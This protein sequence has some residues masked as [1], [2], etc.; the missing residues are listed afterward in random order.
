MA[1]VSSTL[2]AWS[3][4]AGSNNPSGSTTIGA[5]LD[6][7]LREMQAVTR[8]FLAGKG[9]AIASAA[10]MDL[11]TMDGYYASVTGNT[12]VTGLGTES[13]GISYWLRTASTPQFT[14]GAAAIVLPGGANLVAAAGDI[15]RFTS[16]GS[17]V[18]VLSGFLPA[19]I[20]GTGSMVRAT[21]PTL[22]GA[23]LGS[24]TVA[25]TQA[26]SDNSTK[27][28]TTAYIDRGSSGASLVLIDTKTASSSSSLDFTTGIS[29]TYD[30]YVFRLVNVLP[31]TDSV[32]LYFRVS[33]DGGST[34]KQAASDYNWAIYGTSTLG[35][36]GTSSGGGT[37]AQIALTST[38][39]SFTMAN[40][41]NGGWCGTLTLVAPSS[42]A[43]HKR[44]SYE[45]IYLNKEA[46]TS[47]QAAVG[48]GGAYIGATTAINAV[49]F[50]HS[51]G[52]IASGTIYL[53]GVRKT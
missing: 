35:T 49:Q 2:R 48:G 22:S 25:T 24:S 8:K 46:G 16:E 44:V 20:T 21:A 51:S 9:T 47:T 11:T 4:T 10:T 7:N 31:A 23:N 33:T 37:V 18:W 17:G 36:G 34:F 15:F 45:G 12:T 19:G 27:V 14:H 6:D 42:T 39:A 5:G 28:A 30:F 52:N 3:G 43:A 38:V 29:S 13:A 32:H 41:A 40:T 53:Y 1:D 50:F 26:A